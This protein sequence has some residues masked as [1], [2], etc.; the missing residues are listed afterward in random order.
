MGIN[1]K[2][3]NYFKDVKK[4]I[5]LKVQIIVKILIILLILIK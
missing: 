3:G 5:K 2:E 4:V 1:A